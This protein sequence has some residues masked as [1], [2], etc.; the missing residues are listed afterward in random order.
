MAA[1]THAAVSGSGS[2]GAGGGGGG[3]AGSGSSSDHRVGPYEILKEIGKGSFAVVHKGLVRPPDAPRARDLAIKIVS[4]RK[5]TTKLLE[6]LEGEISIMRNIRH[7]HVVELLD[8]LS[9]DDRIYLVMPFCSGGD[10]SFYI[11]NAPKALAEQ[12]ALASAATAE[13]RKTRRST[14]IDRSAATA[15]MEYRH[16]EDGGLNHVVIRSFLEQLAGALEFMRDRNIVHRDIKP[17]NLLLQPADE[18]FLA[19]GHKPGI[20][21]LK[22]ADFGFARNLPTATLAET[23]CGSPLYMAPEILRYEKYDAKADLW[24]VGAVLYEMCVGKPPFRAQNPVELL[25]K[26][27]RGE[28]RIRFPDERS[29]GSLARERE[30]REELGETNVDVKR[31]HSIPADIKALVRCLLRQKPME[32]VSFDG[33]FRC[34]VI[35]GVREEMRQV[36]AAAA[37]AATAKRALAD[38]ATTSAGATSESSNAKLIPAAPEEM[39]PSLPKAA[40]IP[41]SKVNVSPPTPI[42]RGF[43]SKYVLAGNH[44]YRTNAVETKAKMAQPSIA[45]PTSS[46]M[47]DNASDTPG[48]SVSNFPIHAATAKA[49]SS[50]S[51]GT[52]AS[53]PL[54]LAGSATQPS[55]GDSGLL[56]KDAYVIVE[57]RNIET[58][59]DGSVGAGLL[60]VGRRPSRLGRLSSGIA[61]QLLPS[62][63]AVTATATA[64]PFSAAKTT[65]E[66]AQRARISPPNRSSP[67][68]VEGAAPSSPAGGAFA[69]PSG[70]V[71][72]PSLSHRQSTSSA[73]SPSPRS[74]PAV[75][76]AP[77]AAAQSGVASTIPAPDPA[78]P[79]T[80]PA[81][82]STTTTA[83]NPQSALARAISMASVR[84]FGIP[85][86]MNMRGAAAL[87][88]NRS[89]RRAA[90]MRSGEHLDGAEAGL[91]AMLED[92]S[93]KSFVLSEFADSRLA[94][95]FPSGPH[96]AGLNGEAAKDS[97]LGSS[98]VST[99]VNKSTRPSTALRR[100]SS[101]KASPGAPAASYSPTSPQSQTI[102]LPSSAGETVA[103]EALLLYVR[104]LSFLQRGLDAVKIFWEARSRPGYP[105][106]VSSDVNEAVQFLRARFNDG[107]ERAD[108]AR[109]R[110]SAEIPDSARNV[111]KLIF[112]KALDIARCAA[113][114]ELENNHGRAAAA[115]GSAFEAQRCILAYETASGLLSGLLDSPNEKEEGEE[116]SAAAAAVA[117]V[118][119]GSN[120]E[121]G[122]AAIATIEKFLASINKRLAA[123]QRSAVEMPSSQE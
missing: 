95:H 17:Q 62:A 4:R 2:G 53:T 100:S 28:D 24:S 74:L 41:S 9:T 107:Y 29:D 23:L 42:K 47:E 109:A 57:K 87:A 16:H 93:Q 110:C 18:E 94:L 112:D 26:I 38:Q 104:S 67:T 64:A 5:L 78:A 61:A 101:T 11:R 108:F 7:R 49:S 119:L 13:A 84:L 122:D 121:L 63:A 39:A 114:D 60:G 116:E 98:S 96:Q 1:V 82:I 99:A 118:V 40:R 72:R 52:G 14:S 12:Q 90:L 50:D 68:A 56:G 15:E 43:A 92:L 77:A 30:R 37:A 46:G 117:A 103:A 35:E 25:R 44:A 76:G 69:L 80:A 71:R 33:L 106:A 55:P 59:S 65:D 32:R 31:A 81:A 36:V 102:G 10:L 48:S 54:D 91:L 6:N 21:Q 19:A 70:T 89:T 58:N 85:T 115:A 88:R 105:A 123:L 111:D 27:E 73:T 97:A 120:A 22:V 3:G 34:D 45:A 113:L 51:P 8:C 20:P 79:Q 86:G 75:G 83:A 66:S